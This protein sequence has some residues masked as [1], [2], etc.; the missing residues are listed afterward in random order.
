MRVLWC[1]G[2]ISLLWSGAEAAGGNTATMTLSLSETFSESTTLTLPTGTASATVTMT[3]PTATASETH[4][5]SQTTTFTLPTSTATD[6]VTLTLPTATDSLTHSLTKSA[7]FSESLTASLSRTLSLT[8]SASLTE[9]QSLSESLSM[10]V[11]EFDNYTTAI[12][13]ADTHFEGQ[14]VRISLT[15]SLSGT[16]VSLFNTS[17]GYGHLHMKVWVY[18]STYGHD[19][20]TYQSQ[21]TSLPHYETRQ[22]G[23]SSYDQPRFIRYI[24]TA[25]MTFAAPIDSVEYIICFKHTP[26]LDL[27]D[28]RTFRFSFSG[29]WMLFTTDG[30]FDGNP[31]GLDRQ[32]Y[33]FRS[34]SSPVRYYLPSPLRGQ[35]AA[36]E[37][38]SIATA[39]NLTRPS[40]NCTGTTKE[41]CRYGDSLK[42][43]PQGAPCTYEPVAFTSD[44][45]YGGRFV[46]PDGSW[47]WDGIDGVFLGATAGGVGMFGHQDAH[48]LVE[49]RELFAST[50]YEPEPISDTTAQTLSRR[51]AYAYLRLPRETGS[52]DVCFSAQELRKEWS[53]KNATHLE[54]AP[55]WMKLYPCEAARCVSRAAARTTPSFTPGTTPLGWTMLDVRPGTYGTIRVDD[56]GAKTLSRVAVHSRDDLA[57]YRNY[58]S[59]V[60]GD[61]LRIVPV[62]YFAEAYALR[63]TPNDERPTGSTPM[64]GCWHRGNDRVWDEGTDMPSAVRDF[65]DDPTH[66]RATATDDATAVDAVY[67]GLYIPD[68]GEWMVCYRRGGAHGWTPLPYHYSASGSVPVKWR[69][70]ETAYTPLSTFSQTADWGPTV[71]HYAPVVKIATPIVPGVYGTDAQIAAYPPEVTYYANDTRRGTWGPVTV[72]NVTDV[73]GLTSSGVLGRL[74]S[75]PWSFARTYA[76]TDAVIATAGSALR[77]V[78]PSASCDAPNFVDLSAQSLDGGD[79]ECNNL[80]AGLDCAGSSHDSSTTD[81]VSYYVSFPPCISAGEPSGSSSA[82][83]CLSPDYCNLCDDS[84]TD[85]MCAY[86]VCWRHGGYNW[87]IVAPPDF[88]V[89]RTAK[90]WRR[91]PVSDYVLNEGVPN[92]RAWRLDD[93]AP[94]FLGTY[95]GSNAAWKLLRLAP[96]PTLSLT[97]LETRAGVEAGFVVRDTSRALTIGYRGSCT[98]GVRCDN[99]GDVFRLVESTDNCDITPSKWA[100][101][102]KQYADTHMSLLCPVAGRGSTAASGLL[103][104]PC[105][106]DPKLM[107]QSCG[108]GVCRHATPEMQFLLNARSSPVYTGVPDPYDD[109]VP[110]DSIYVGSEYAFAT[111]VL[112]PYDTSKAYKQC[113][114]QATSPNWIVFNETVVLEEPPSF[115]VEPEAAYLLLGGELQDV[116]M[117]ARDPFFD[118]ISYFQAKFVRSVGGDT[119]GCSNLAGGTEA[120]PY[121]GSTSSYVANSTQLQFY[122][123]VPQR[124]GLYWLCVR[125]EKT[126]QDSLS[127]FKFG[128]YVVMDNQVR[129]S[130]AQ[131]NLPI[132]QGAAEVS[133]RRCLW[134]ETNEFC[135]TTS[136]FETFTTDPGVDMAKIVPWGHACHA[137]LADQQSHGTSVHVG[138]EGGGVYGV[139]DLGPADGLANVAV[140]EATLP[141]TAEDA[142]ATY[143][144]CVRSFFGSV[145]RTAWAEVSEATAVQ[146]QVF[147]MNGT[148]K[149]HFTTQASKVRNWVLKSQLEAYTKLQLS[150]IVAFGGA[151][152][153][154]VE[155]LTRGNPYAESGFN[156]SVYSAS[157]IISVG[158]THK[159]KLVK[160]KGF[161][162]RLPPTPYTGA[163]WVSADVV[164]ATC[165]SPGTV[166]TLTGA[167]SLCSD[168]NLY[169]SVACPNI[170]YSSATSVFEV[171]IQL[172]VE[173][174][175][176]L[177]CY[178]FENAVADLQTPWLNLM[179]VNGNGGLWAVS[180]FL[181]FDAGAVSAVSP[182]FDPL[183]LSDIRTHVGTSL[184]SWCATGSGID[185]VTENTGTHFTVDWVTLVND[186]MN[187]PAVP[188]PNA[189]SWTGG[190]YYATK[191]QSNE[192]TRV[193]GGMRV[194]PLVASPSNRYKVCLLKSGDWG[195]SNPGGA[196][197]TL[198]KRGVSYQLWNRASPTSKTLGHTGYLQPSLTNAI[199]EISA[200]PAHDYNSSLYFMLADAD[201]EALYTDVDRN[202]LSVSEPG[203]PSSSP[204]IRSGEYVDV[205]VRALSQGR[206][207]SFSDMAFEVKLCTPVETW[208]GVQCETVA[209]DDAPPFELI[210]TQPTCRNGSEYGWP[211]GG[212]KQFLQGGSAVLR[213]QYRS[214]CPQGTY[215]LNPGCGIKISAVTET[216]QLLVSKPIW[217]NVQRN[218]PDAVAVDFDVRGAPQRLDTFSLPP[219]SKDATCVGPPTCLLITC[220]THRLCSAFVMAL[221]GGPRE[222]A[223]LGSFQVTYSSFDYGTVDNALLDLQQS[224]SSG[225]RQFLD[226]EWSRSGTFNI[227]FTPKL[228]AGA[229]EGVVFYNIT[230]GDPLGVKSWTRLILRV[231]RPQPLRLLMDSVMALDS[232]ISQHNQRQPVPVWHSEVVPSLDFTLAP[233]SLS[234]QSGSYLESLIP[235]ELHFRV[236]GSFE[237]A[238]V[239]LEGDGG[240]QDLDGWALHG[241]V[242]GVIGNKLL[243]VEYDPPCVSPGC[244]PNAGT[245]VHAAA[246]LRTSAAYS[247]TLPPFTPI[248]LE[249][250][251]GDRVGSELWAIRFRVQS[252]MGCGRI[253]GTA[254]GGNGCV[255]S[256]SLRPTVAN[257]AFSAVTATVATPVRTVAST[258]SVVVDRA[259]TPL[260]EGVTVTLIPGTV[261]GR[262]EGSDFLVDEFH[263][264]D[265]F[266]LIA[267][268]GPLLNGIMNRDGIRADAGTGTDPVMHTPTTILGPFGRTWGVQ[269]TLRPTRPCVLCE[270]TFHSTWGAGPTSAVTKMGSATLSFTDTANGIFCTPGLVTP[271]IVGY[272]SGSLLTSTFGINVTAAVIDTSVSTPVLWP[273]WS[274][275]ID[276][277]TG[278][279]IPDAS[280]G[281]VSA[282]STV[283]LSHVGTT[284]S[285]FRVGMGA[286]GVA[287]FTDLQLELIDTATTAAFPAQLDFEFQTFRVKYSNTLPGSV[288]ESTV[289]YT[290]KSRAAIERSNTQAAKFIE[291]SADAVTGAE[292][293][294]DTSVA[295]CLHWSTTVDGVVGF[296]IN[297]FRLTSGVK[298]VYENHGGTPSA[299]I[300]SRA[301]TWT[302]TATTCSTSSMTLQSG[303][304]DVIH[305]GGSAYTYGSSGLVMTKEAKQPSSGNMFVSLGEFTGPVR[306]TAI[307]L[308]LTKTTDGNELIDSSVDCV[309]VYLYIKPTAIDK[310]YIGLAANSLQSEVMN[311]GTEICGDGTLATLG[312]ILYY[313]FNSKRY[314]AYERSFTYTV[315]TAA[316]AVFAQNHS[317]VTVG[318]LSQSTGLP[319]GASTFV[320]HTHTF[321]PVAWI[322]LY[323]LNPIA[324]PFTFHMEGADN[325]E[326]VSVSA[327]ESP[328]SYTTSYTVQGYSAFEIAEAPSHDDECVQKVHL[329]TTVLSYR[330][331]TANPGTGW[332]Y[333]T[334]GAVVGVPFP[335]QARVS[336]LGKRSHAYPATRVL[337]TK[338]SATAC[339]DG[340]TLT[341]YHTNPSKET[342]GIRLLDGTLANSFVPLTAGKETQY[343]QATVW[344][345]FSKPCEACT[346][347]VTL[348]YKAASFSSD[349]ASC[350]NGATT[351]EKQPVFG[352]RSKT[353]KTFT[354]RFPAE[355]S[356]HVTEQ[357]VQVPTAVG[358]T[359]TVK[360]DIVQ[361]QAGWTSVVPMEHRG[362]A[363]VWAYPKFTATASDAATLKYGN[364]GFL[365]S[366]A[367]GGSCVVNN[368][369]FEKSTLNKWAA[370]STTG[371]LSFFLT[372]PC[373]AC[374]VWLRYDMRPKSGARIVGDFPL[375]HYSTE[376]VASMSL[377]S[378]PHP[379]A[380]L[381]FNVKTCG[382]TWFIAGTPPAAVKRRA[383]FSVS[384]MRADGNFL[385][386]FDAGSVPAQLLELPSDKVKKGNGGG[387]HLIN[388]GPLQLQEPP[389]ISVEGGV[390]TM[391]M[392]YSRACY[393][394]GFT[395]SG[396]E[397]RL[398]V[399]TDATQVIANPI[400]QSKLVQVMNG[401]NTVSYAFEV[402]AADEL[403]DRSY[404][405]GG[406]SRLEWNAPYQQSSVSTAEL[407]LVLPVVEP[408]TLSDE[409]SRSV[410]LLPSKQTVNSIRIASGNMIQ[411]GIPNGIVQGTVAGRMIVTLSEPVTDLPLGLKVGGSPE[412]L[413]T[414]M[415]GGLLPPRITHTVPADRFFIR[416][417]DTQRVQSVSVG[418]VLTVQV[419]AA[420]PLPGASAD[421]LTYYISKDA[422]G[423][424]FSAFAD[425][426]G[427]ASPQCLN[428]E[429]AID[430]RLGENVTKPAVAGAAAFEVRIQRA[431]LPTGVTVLNCLL[432]VS[433]TL[434]PS[435]VFALQLS[436]GQREPGAWA[437]T[438]TENY[439]VSGAPTLASVA[440]EAARATAKTISLKLW[441]KTFSPKSSF[442]QGPALTVSAITLTMEPPGCFVTDALPYATVFNNMVSWSGQFTSEGT[443]TFSSVSGL[444]VSLAQ[445]LVT[446]VRN[447]V[448]VAMHGTT[449]E[450][451]FTGLVTAKTLAG[452]AAAMTSSPVGVTFQ[453]LDATGAVNKGD[454]SSLIQLEGSDGVESQTLQA[455]AKNGL[456]TVSW[457]PKRPTRANAAASHAPWWFV[458][459]SS[460]NKPFSN[461]G[462]LY[463][464]VRAT[465]L[466]LSFKGAGAD[467]PWQRLP[468]K[469]R[470]CAVLGSAQCKAGIAAPVG[471][472]VSYVNGYP[473]SLRLELEDEYGNTPQTAEDIGFNANLLFQ[474]L[475]VPCLT[476]DRALHASDHRQYSKLCHVPGQC[477][478]SPLQDCGLV[479]WITGQLS[480]LRIPMVSTPGSTMAVIGEGATP[481]RYTAPYSGLGRFMITSSRVDYTLEA[482]ESTWLSEI[483]FAK[484][485]TVGV[486]G[487]K[488]CSV[489]A[490]APSEVP[491]VH[492]HLGQ[493]PGLETLANGTVTTEPLKPFELSLAIMDDT[494]SVVEGDNYTHVDL[495]AVCDPQ[496]W[497]EHAGL[498][499]TSQHFSFSPTNHTTQGA[500]FSPDFAIGNLTGFMNNQFVRV[501]L[502]ARA[503][504]VWP[505]L[506]RNR[507]QHL[508]TSTSFT[509]G[510]CN[511]FKH[512]VCLSL[513]E[514]VAALQHGG[515]P[516][517]PGL[518]AAHQ[519]Q[520]GCHADLV[521]GGM[522]SFARA[523]HA[524]LPSPSC[525]QVASKPSGPTL[526][527]T[528]VPTTPGVRKYATA[529]LQL[530]SI[531]FSTFNST[532][533]EASLFADMSARG[534]AEL[535]KIVTEVLCN[536]PTTR[537]HRIPPITDLDKANPAVCLRF[538]QSI[539]AARVAYALQSNLAS[540]DACPCAPLVE[541]R[542]E[543]LSPGNA[544]VQNALVS[545]LQQTAADPMAAT[546]A[547][548]SLSASS[549]TLLST[550]ATPVPA[551]STPSPPNPVT[552]TPVPEPTGSN[553]ATDE[554][555]VVPEYTLEGSA[556]AQ[557]HLWLTSAVWLLILASLL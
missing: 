121:G 255:L 180:P 413:P 446:T 227:T 450:G 442:V 515:C 518:Y 532:A 507:P 301:A 91:V 105:S 319:P 390:G 119:D 548:Y 48:P 305:A 205:L 177:V 144:V 34:T 170:A 495:S 264:G 197:L 162:V 151:S 329:P 165:R 120:T 252:G 38:N 430:G 441:D 541:F 288:K 210:N 494:F 534:A 195:V 193:T 354:V 293:L 241:E 229:N 424:T 504:K 65:Q 137:G 87:Q 147:S 8:H 35:Y 295:T 256:F 513:L 172:P 126:A 489:A 86:R 417:F 376:P 265:M 270:F 470:D 374:Q 300:S 463:V 24:R 278:V 102:Q 44:P 188:L 335:I 536:I 478:S 333:Q 109:V 237:G 368:P 380:P 63:V 77:L 230:Y 5:L 64:L 40:S 216:G 510:H 352:E 304:S 73:T 41:S 9:T 17:G 178:T 465:V 475:A 370:K 397:M 328:G 545:A 467:S 13:P 433:S 201:T 33:V 307:D 542:M 148:A 458:A 427:A 103:S 348:C 212:L 403:G 79:M 456:V 269:Y 192:T 99:T 522:P 7:T 200:T 284:A 356:L 408:I 466:R 222:F 350:L 529:V 400:D 388:T 133:L 341:S 158:G 231:V 294:C 460:Q 426:A 556:V 135:D 56:G 521:C 535:T 549:V 451:N 369:E 266:A 491:Y 422:P 202:M 60:G 131:G 220:R 511:I 36:M 472:R 474:P 503:V 132:N 407:R 95:Y 104:W 361:D 233:G 396:R 447:S 550:G 339:N 243:A 415:L 444:G 39:W 392:M 46:E 492:C 500:V 439:V 101:G 247:T 398:A 18:S 84:G 371:Q 340:G 554:P 282:T 32:D 21:T 272:A 232:G 337:V 379:G 517:R 318:S 271:Q 488:L 169:D 11:N 114:K 80:H 250:L 469:Y 153:R 296:P 139:Q 113:Y 481:L 298:E 163:G 347:Q 404:S 321:D 116:T 189:T 355:T 402:Y 419:V 10:T 68:A 483:Y 96:S 253:A 3:L 377:A 418:D 316:G 366:A 401:T 62:E 326:Q 381:V 325:D 78:H 167:D 249:K 546:A 362:E 332:G 281:A 394:C 349:P 363:T 218:K 16:E 482:D 54:Q 186:T 69:H 15:T 290:C 215:N 496:V 213:L 61:Q 42:L 72:S 372:R 528:P 110:G 276:A 414:R 438:T 261:D 537:T 423:A 219:A 297:V 176:Y 425:C 207:A 166:G 497:P 125:V 431:T 516:A 385:P 471:Q 164:G 443:C 71:T 411:D 150:G 25:Y 459:Y 206:L 410:T 238:E 303:F 223:S 6:T 58:F 538:A 435:A 149:A 391:R 557:P 83:G 209:A 81:T 22:Y 490:V 283:R 306:A 485:Y 540:G 155:G 531:D 506:P 280:G 154:V 477:V 181:E 457:T 416:N 20:S 145:K 436:I 311:A 544:A 434:R 12:V 526:P 76:G 236:V 317:A 156:L 14:E 533:F 520:H 70:L 59:V 509:S 429:V 85:C 375:R 480:Y 140:F 440:G 28:Y 226:N 453:I 309:L 185:C 386:S 314:V 393:E 66:A 551:P 406:P 292:A 254:P 365:Y 74:S 224:F 462:P 141:A 359:F 31:D 486:V 287:A 320:Q 179:D 128:R 487:L 313:T 344:P 204:V 449:V 323:V 50:P 211:D 43:V 367:V 45:Y 353:T 412:T 19:C 174:G 240:K 67:G 267:S 461:I 143:K 217:V 454:F 502:R 1:L 97:Y 199:D 159:F 53:L 432:K 171:D 501:R 455:Q 324:T 553:N 168:P 539:G 331:F 122:L 161:D 555:E 327:I 124:Q 285:I 464:V 524:L 4:S 508:S 37:I 382:S 228:K 312:M 190:K 291:L 268:P 184:S 493:V 52:F 289:R 173:P 107:T 421:D 308:C 512:R 519:S 259:V 262:V 118:S 338:L 476:A 182:E 257:S 92:T 310:H 525:T 94:G 194:P 221:Y 302:C 373:K 115:F 389:T 336:H 196:N 445:S 203:F 55:M 330:A 198:V 75:L 552:D 112:P 387:G 90:G 30:I 123:T 138:R 251:H 175:F 239:L 82:P 2:A 514:R 245:V 473:F 242:S 505:V 260:Q 234:A 191:L 26:Y 527:P 146:G 543:A 334:H 27:G 49:Q 378:V 399:L 47:A 51:T 315:K 152:T 98:G 351:D 111:V 409:T 57:A 357:S 88:P 246:N 383:H 384:V 498:F 428:C 530:G 248:A 468:V 358:D 299:R 127:W 187:C 343:G 360:Y 142:Q 420:G 89:D 263:Y 452:K 29:Q 437:W 225:V 279:T 275:F 405:A 484:P 134:R 183:A 23:M 364:G 117:M 208:A 108:G 499:A 346:L 129:W 342:D 157:A 273:R 160:T 130:I 286:G 322:S 345:T 448:A 93:A 214:L 106:S 100:A 258:V 523:L 547:A 235:Y 274:V 136:S 395:I 479:N 244:H 277:Q